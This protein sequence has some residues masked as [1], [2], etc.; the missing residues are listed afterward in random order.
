MDE[1]FEAIRDNNIRDVRSAVEGNKALINLQDKD[2]QTALMISCRD[3][4]IDIARFLLGHGADIDAKDHEDHTALQ[5]SSYDGAEEIVNMIKAAHTADRLL[6]GKNIGEIIA[7]QEDLFIE[8]VCRL[9]HKKFSQHIYEKFIKYCDDHH[10]ALLDEHQ[11]LLEI[12]PETFE[13]DLSAATTTDYV[14][15]VAEVPWINRP[16][17]AFVKEGST[18]FC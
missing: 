2:G 6:K 4:H 3:S 11:E 18:D 13:V 15:L 5:R 10:W 14:P 16:E 1:F 17:W 8:R 9:L 12:N 7:G